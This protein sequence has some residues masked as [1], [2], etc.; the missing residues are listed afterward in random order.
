MKN[1]VISTRIRPLIRYLG[2]VVGLVVGTPSG[3]GCL[4]WLIHPT[5]I[6]DNPIAVAFCFVLFPLIAW[7]TYRWMSIGGTLSKNA[8]ILRGWF[9]T[10]NISPD[11]LTEIRRLER[12]VMSKNV[13]GA[14]GYSARTEY[15]YEMFDHRGESLGE[16]PSAVSICKDW[17]QFFQHMQELAAK[18]RKLTPTS[19]VESR[20]LADIPPD[21]WTA[22][23][24]ERYEN[25]D[26]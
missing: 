5:E 2:F 9:S 21:E 10:V 3:F 23:D 4:W 20:N 18:S 26:E 8:L 16:V 17:D 22:E 13:S 12:T 19:D 24:I 11:A 15:Y 1:D 14:A 6:V 25:E 7:A